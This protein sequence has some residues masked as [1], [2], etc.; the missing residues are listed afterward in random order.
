MSL[1]WMLLLFSLLIVAHELGHLFVARWCGVKVERFGLGLPF[2][3]PIWKRRVGSGSDS[4]ELCLHAIPLGGYVAFPDDDSASRIPLGSR[5]RFENQPPLN[6]TAIVLAGV[7]VNALLAWVLTLWIFIGWGKP[8]ADTFVV[9]TL[10]E[11]AHQPSSYIAAELLIDTTQD[12]SPF[13]RNARLLLNKTPLTIATVPILE[14]LHTFEALPSHERVLTFEPLVTNAQP[15][16][17]IASTLQPSIASRAGLLP[18]DRILQVGDTPLERYPATGV[19][20]LMATLKSHKAQPV[21]I[22]VQHDPSILEQ[23]QPQ[24]AGK[25]EKLSDTKKKAS[26]ALSVLQMPER[27]IDVMPDAEGRIG[28]QLGQRGVAIAPSHLG[29]AALSAWDFLGGVVA[30]NT[31]GL[32]RLVQGRIQ[33]EELAGPVRIV[34]AGAKIIERDGLHSG[35]LLAAVISMILAV[36]NLLP[37]PPLDGSYLV[38]IIIESITGKKLNKQVQQVLGSLGFWAFLLLSAYVLYNDVSQLI[39]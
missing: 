25:P 9:K 33:K 19:Q 34:S 3:Q 5:K 14:T 11:L 13:Y 2:G 10:T 37:I 39:K 16:E 4:L 32:T 8:G 28:V 27:I 15:L 18:G 20:T 38:Y 6:K 7:A 26:D 36:M 1:L 12:P 29:D 17:T 22:V 35:I 21:S 23:I 30:Q 24:E 31:E